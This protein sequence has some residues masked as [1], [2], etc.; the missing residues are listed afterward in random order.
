M[1]S[2]ALLR[3]INVG[4][5]NTVRMAELV[6]LLQSLHFANVRSYLQSGNF[7]FDHGRAGPSALSDG[8]E[9]AISQ[10]FGFDVK[11]IVRTAEE[12]RSLISG[13]PLLDMPEIDREKLH[14][15]FLKDTP[16]KPD[17][18]YFEAIKEPKERL[19][20]KGKEVFLYCPNGYGRSKL[21]NQ[22][23]EKKQGVAATTR[24]WKTVNALAEMVTTPY[25]GRVI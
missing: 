11:V 20:I 4:G 17:I 25:T 19:R 13:N 15:T 14:V 8:I 6:S 24:N 21:T 12:L 10:K 7:V 9:Q 5:K 2:I 22:A 16:V 1:T 23:F 3:G 18:S